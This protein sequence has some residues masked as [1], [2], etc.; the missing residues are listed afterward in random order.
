MNGGPS[1][2]KKYGFEIMEKTIIE[3]CAYS[4]QSVLNAF[5]A[6]ADRVELCDNMYEGGTTPSLGAVITAKGVAPIAL[7]V[8]IRPRGGDFCYSDVEFEVMKKDIELVKQT[9]ADGI[10]IGI[11]NPDGTVDIKRTAELVKTASPLPVTFH[12]AFDITA[13]PFDA[14]DAVIDTGA[15]RILTS[16]QM[17]NAFD[18]KELIKQ[19]VEKAGESIIIMP[20]GGV[21][22]NNI[23]Q[24]IEETGASEFHLSAKKYFPGKMEYKKEGV[25]INVKDLIP[26]Y[27]VLHSDQQT[28]RQI[29]KLVQYQT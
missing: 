20:G 28:I 25:G 18:G 3:V 6:G 26:E 12:R 21:N 11:L 27:E 17:A 2:I 10:V 7:N 23:L 16:G 29:V 24:L 14:L 13:S 9:G 1:F 15:A 22:S 5:Y 4:V 8:I 19:L